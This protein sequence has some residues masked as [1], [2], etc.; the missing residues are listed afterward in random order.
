LAPFFCLPGAKSY[1]P[2]PIFRNVGERRRL[3]LPLCGIR[4]HRAFCRVETRVAQKHSLGRFHR[5]YGWNLISD[6]QVIGVVKTGAGFANQGERGG[7][8]WQQ[9]TAR[10]D[11]F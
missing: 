2:T 5:P 10:Q 6:Q 8:P 4:A 1:T 3:I 7:Y 11:Y 9:Q